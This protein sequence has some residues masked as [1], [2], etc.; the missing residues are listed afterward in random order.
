[1]KR[2][3]II[4]GL[5]AVIFSLS[6][7]GCGGELGRL[8]TNSV[9]WQGPEIKNPG[10]KSDVRVEADEVYARYVKEQEQDKKIEYGRRAFNM[11]SAVGDFERAREIA[12]GMLKLDSDRGLIYVKFLDNSMPPAE[13]KTK[14]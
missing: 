1:M 5:A 7:A 6:A 9:G 4:A 14:Q 12:R 10:L 3:K 11:Y 2:S 8:F 13:E